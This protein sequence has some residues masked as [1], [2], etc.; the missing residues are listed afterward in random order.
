MYMHSLVNSSYLLVSRSASH[1]NCD[2]VSASLSVSVQVA[3]T[4]ANV[5]THIAFTFK[6]GVGLYAYVELG[7]QRQNC[8]VLVSYNRPPPPRPLPRSFERGNVV[9]HTPHTATMRPVSGNWCLGSPGSVSSPVKSM[10][11]TNG[12]LAE[13]RVWNVARSEAQVTSLHTTA[14]MALDSLSRSP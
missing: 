5:W 1:I 6:Q 13:F 12:S 9:N 8:A 7:Q 3:T 4:T 11:H 10:T 2:Y 14:T